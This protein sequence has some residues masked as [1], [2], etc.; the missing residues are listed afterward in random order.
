LAQD[1]NTDR[2]FIYYAGHGFTDYAHNFAGYITAHNTSSFNAGIANAVAS[3]VRIQEIDD[4]LQ[5]SL[6][7]QIMVVFDSCFAGTTFNTRVFST[8]PLGINEE[9]IV[10]NV[11]QQPVIT[12]ITAGRAKLLECDKR[13]G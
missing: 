5:S 9:Q 7:K 6:A 2:F 3:A 12:Y 8:P 13:Q 11:V 10:S 1:K 4:I